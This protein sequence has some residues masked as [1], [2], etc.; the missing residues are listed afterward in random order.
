M[1]PGDILDI[2]SQLI[3]CLQSWARSLFFES[4]SWYDRIIVIVV[5]SV[6]RL[7]DSLNKCIQ[8][9]LVCIVLCRTCVEIV[10]INLRLYSGISRPE[11]DSSG[12]V[13]SFGFERIPRE[14]LMVCHSKVA[15]LWEVA[16]EV[17]RPTKDK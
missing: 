10:E 1:T 7:P 15:P 12:L 14:M 6:S 13:S 9:L 11:L 2:L 16:N 8:I 4:G 17:D 3:I 5:E